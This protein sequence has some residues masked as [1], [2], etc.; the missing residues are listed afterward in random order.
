[1]F[2][3]VIFRIRRLRFTD[4]SSELKAKKQKLDDNFLRKYL[5]ERKE[6]LQMARE[7]IKRIERRDFY[8]Y[9]GE[10]TPLVTNEFNVTKVQIA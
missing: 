8:K 9:I 3:D 10:T 6:K 4:L 7:L 5:K 2:D 1:M